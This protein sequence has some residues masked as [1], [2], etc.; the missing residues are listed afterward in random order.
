METKTVRIGGLV[1]DSLVD[2]PGL[3]FVIFFQGCPHHC[4]GCHNPHS[5]DFSGGMT[6]DISELVGLWKQNKMID[7]LTFSG[8]EPFAQA[9]SL[10]VLLEKAKESGLN[11]L[12]YTGYRYEELLKNEL[13]KAILALTDILID[14]LYVEGEK[15]ANLLYRGSANQRIIDVA[16]SLSQ[17][18]I[19]EI[20]Y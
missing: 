19:I 6:K 8:G 11:T 3:R 14:G 17:D 10:L 1:T 12:I 13:Y 15:S 16:K 9:N 5:W 20:N 7:G 2:G 4:P 18:K